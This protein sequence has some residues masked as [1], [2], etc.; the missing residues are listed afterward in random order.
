ML[1]RA[2]L[3]S[4]AIAPPIYVLLAQQ[5]AESR[6]MGVGALIVANSLTTSV[7]APF[8]GYLADKACRAVMAI[9]AAG[10]GLLCLFTFAA[11]IYLSTVGRWSGVDPQRT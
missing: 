7:S 6:L 1:A 11:V 8:W 3:L 10:V 9:A 4:V 5:Q 2:L